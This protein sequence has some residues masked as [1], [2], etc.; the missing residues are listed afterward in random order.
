MYERDVRGYTFLGTIEEKPEEAEYWL[1]KTTQIV[2]KQLACLDEH[3]LERAIALLADEA[4]SWCET[5][6][7]TAPAKK[8]MWNFF[9]EEVKKKYISEQYLNDRRNRFL[10]LKQANKWIEQYM[11]EFFMSINSMGKS[12]EAPPCQ[13]CKKP[14][15]GQCRLHSNLCY[16]CG[17]SGH[18]IRDCPQIANQ[19]STRPLVPVSASPVSKNRGP[20]QAQSAVQG[21]GKAS[22]SNAQTHQESRAS[23]LIYH[24]RSRKVQ[25]KNIVADSAIKVEY[26][27]AS[28]ATKEIVWIKKFIFE[29]RVI[30]TIADVVELH[31]DNNE[32]FMQVKEPRSHQRSKHT[33][34]CFHP[35]R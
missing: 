30:T 7:L 31:C 24:V 25:S 2:T 22:H 13:Y 11:A 5:T 12:K 8:I 9:V 15:W 19:A 28:E 17:G 29:L 10:H 33:L 3:K 27:A 18:Y 1:E 35:I 16:V 34:K 26:I 6:T 4:L 32:A 21:R 23:T 20:K 14:H